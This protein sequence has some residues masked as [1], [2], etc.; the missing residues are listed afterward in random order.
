[1]GGLLPIP[2]EETTE[3]KAARLVKLHEVLTVDD[4]E[5]RYREA[6]HLEDTKRADEERR[7]EKR[8]LQEKEELAKM[9]KQ[10]G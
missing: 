4:E 6:K 1:M 2:V 3:E 9:E 5:V 8:N 10:E 7:V